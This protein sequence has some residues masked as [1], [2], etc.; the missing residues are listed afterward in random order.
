VS[1]AKPAPAPQATTA[2]IRHADACNQ[3]KDRLFEAA[4]EDDFER[5]YRTVRLLCVD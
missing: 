2:D 1:T 5:A 4:S 3:A